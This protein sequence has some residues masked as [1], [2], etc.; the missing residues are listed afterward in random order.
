MERD[1]TGNRDGLIDKIQRLLR[2]TT[3]SGCTEPEALAALDKARALMDAYEVSEEELALT[4]EE[5]AIL[6]SEPPGSRD[7]HNIKFLL[8]R[9]VS[10]FSNCKAWK[11]PSGIVFCG[12]PSDVRLASWL[13]D[14]LTAFVQAELARHLM[15]CLAPRSERRFIINGFVGGCCERISYRLN[16]LCTQSAPAATSNER[17]LTV[18]K[19]AAIDAKMKAEGIT[20]RTSHSCRLRDEASHRA[21]LSAGDRASFGRPVTGAN[22][23]LRIK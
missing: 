15:G 6:R 10:E 20:L 21:G 5:K 4:K 13:L 7:P 14:T 16:A 9:A 23:V 2:K 19:N 22:A 12:L 17:E 11:G 1:V 18:V 8:S 3:A